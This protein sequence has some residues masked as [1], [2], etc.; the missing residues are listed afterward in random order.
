MSFRGVREF[1]EFTGGRAVEQ[2]R[3]NGQI[4]CSAGVGFLG[5]APWDDAGPV[6]VEV[7]DA[8]SSWSPFAFGDECVFRST[9][10]A[11]ALAF[12][13]DGPVEVLEDDGRF[14]SFFPR[15]KG[16]GPGSVLFTPGGRVSLQRLGFS[17]PPLYE[18]TGGRRYLRN[19]GRRFLFD[20]VAGWTAV[21]LQPDG[22]IQSLV[23]SLN[24]DLCVRS[25]FS[26]PVESE[27]RGVGTASP[28]PA[29]ERPLGRFGSAR[30]IRE[31]RSASCSL[32]GPQNRNEME[33]P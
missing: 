10:E 11:V 2:A 28:G 27:R 26:G 6:R 19:S 3:A 20:P 17:E 9:D 5:R 22:C 7:E 23:P 21:G 31:A 14:S 18:E 33:A 13:A 15:A 30:G 24:M 25:G 1:G 12:G 29:T 16:L 8:A 4:V 32:R